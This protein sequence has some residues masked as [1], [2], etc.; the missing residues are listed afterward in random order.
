MFMVHATSL[1]EF[2]FL[3]DNLFDPHNTTEFEQK[4]LKALDKE[5]DHDEVIRVRDI[6][7]S[8]Y[9]WDMYVDQFVDLL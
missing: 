8:K 5:I 7:K 3:G 9:S 2:S 6:V 1:G 4:F